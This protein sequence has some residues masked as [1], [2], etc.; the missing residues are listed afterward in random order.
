[1]GVSGF[2]G[3]VVVLT[4]CGGGTA[5]PAASVAEATAGSE[6][7]VA[8]RPA[9]TST[10][11]TPGTSGATGGGSSGSAGGDGSGSAGA[12]GCVSDAAPVFTHHYTDP[13]QIDFIS[14]T[15]V[16]SAN[17]L[18]NRQYHKVVTDA[19][20]N[21]PEVPVY[22]PTDA[23][24]TG[25]T[26]YA[27]LMYPWQGESFLLAQ[28]DIRFQASCEVYFTFDHVSRLVEPFA[29]LAA[30]EP[31]QDTRNAEVPLRV[32]VSAGQ[33]IGYTSGTEPAHTWDFLVWNT[34][35]R[36]QFAN[37]E[38]YTSRLGGWQGARG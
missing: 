7:T 29:S 21:A 24:A 28:F 36:N 1:M 23:I 2:V 13:E 11:G 30:P 22:A 20:N 15:I 5:Q 31:S 32:E 16:T 6:T 37:Q 17:W 38:R 8:A 26:H 14:P 9:G 12:G 19:E 27:G 18:K 35:Q 3:A 10:V 33:L 4:A 25:V 34:T